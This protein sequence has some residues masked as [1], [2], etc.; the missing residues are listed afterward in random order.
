M[1]ESIFEKLGFTD[2]DFDDIQSADEMT[3][4]PIIGNDRTNKIAKPENLKFERTTG[5]GS[6]RFQNTDDKFSAIIPS[7]LSVITDQRAQDHAMS[8]PNI[9][10][11]KKSK[12]FNNAC[13][14]QSSQGGYISGGDHCYNILPLELRLALLNPSIR[15]KN[16]YSKLWNNIERFNSGIPKVT[17]C[18]GHLEYFFRPYEKELNDFVAEFEPVKNQIGAII[19][20]ADNIAGI[21]ILPTVCHWNYYWIW[22]IRGCYASQLLKLKL[23]NKIRSCRLTIPIISNYT[24]DNIKVNI[25]NS[26]NSTKEL[27]IDKTKSINF[28]VL[29]KKKLSNSFENNIITTSRGGGD[30]IIQDDNPIY[31]SMVECTWK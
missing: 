7:N 17:G 5:Y 26:L 14:V 29:S 15:A 2:I 11:L 16:D 8:E 20:F 3:I 13:C 21:E 1:S 10:S 6:M 4:I 23:T 27:F 25:N 31:L 22:L 24:I 18:G 19:L 30:L 9:V 28:S 12:T